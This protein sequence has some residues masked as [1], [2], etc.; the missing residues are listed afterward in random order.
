[1][2]DIL[3]RENMSHVHVSSYASSSWEA[4]NS[5]DPRAVAEGRRRGI[6]VTGCSEILDYES[7]RF[8]DLILVMEKANYQYVQAL[9]GNDR[10]ERLKYLGSFEDGAS[11]EAEIVD[12]YYG[13][14]RG[15]A[16]CYE[17]MAR[18]CEGVMQSLTS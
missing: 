15:F 14:S 8:L 3:E 9:I 10:P 7:A 4:G 16:S 1:M 5:P 11:N 13:S 12:P 2:K 17:H 6:V 18:C